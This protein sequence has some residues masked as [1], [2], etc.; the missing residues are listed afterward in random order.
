MIGGS[1]RGWEGEIKFG[2]DGERMG[3]RGRDGRERE[4]GREG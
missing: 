1:V 4:D 2:S 3:W